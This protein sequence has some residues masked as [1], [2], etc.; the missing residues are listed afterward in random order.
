MA[1]PTASILPEGA[2]RQPLPDPLAGWIWLNYYTQKI[3]YIPHE[4][5][6]VCARLGLMFRLLP[7]PCALGSKTA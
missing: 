6:K 2:Y 3:I 5:L 7:R 4:Y 1:I